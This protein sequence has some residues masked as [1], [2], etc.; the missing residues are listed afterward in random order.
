MADQEGG[1]RMTRLID[2]NMLLKDVRNSLS[3][4]NIMKRWIIDLIKLQPTI[5]AEPVRHGKWIHKGGGIFICDKCSCHIGL[6]VY[7][8]EKA[9]ERFKWCPHCGARMDEE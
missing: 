3:I 2:A 8:E 6:N 5:Y 4:S 7:T 1:E 9:S